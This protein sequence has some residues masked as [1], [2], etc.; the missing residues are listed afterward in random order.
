MNDVLRDFGS[1]AE[2]K[3]EEIWNDIKDGWTAVTEM[4]NE[5][6]FTDDDRDF[7]WDVLHGRRNLDNQAD[8]NR[9][10]ELMGDKLQKITEKVR[11]RLGLVDLDP[12]NIMFGTGISASAAWVV[13]AS[14]A[15]TG[16]VS[17][18]L[19][20]NTGLDCCCRNCR[21]R[22]WC[23]FWWRCWLAPYFQFQHCGLRSRRI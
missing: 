7:F 1:A 20:R 18:P 6:W 23:N 8:L 13:Q 19:S 17:F 16:H 12:P 2:D 14:V 22:C 15:L 9:L 5:P 3:A 21:P 10:Q 11:Y 4:V